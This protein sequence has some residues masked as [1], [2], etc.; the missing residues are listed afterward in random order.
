MA[1]WAL[2]T[3]RSKDN[4]KGF[5]RDYWEYFYTNEVIA[6]GWGKIDISPNN[7]PSERDIWDALKK[8][9][10]YGYLEKNPRKV[11]S[12]IWNFVNLTEDNNILLCH[13]YSWNQK[14]D[15]RLYGTAKVKDNKWKKKTIGEGERKWECITR[16]ANI[17][18]FNNKD[19]KDI[20]ID[21][22]KGFM[23]ED[24]FFIGTL[25]DLSPE[26]YERIVKWAE[27]DC[28][29]FYCPPLAKGD[30]GGF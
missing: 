11:T 17:V 15:V 3:R 2:K 6:I 10:D 13:G 26:Q 16:K 20:P 23:G 4:N 18:A 8:I 22:L 25:L 14:K 24:K 7:A 1:Y 27:Q 5:I 9:P 21:T 19:G 12:F 29:H 30:K 28:Q